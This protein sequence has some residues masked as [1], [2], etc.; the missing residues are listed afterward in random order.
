MK[1]FE[2]IT[3]Y[4]VTLYAYYYVLDMWLKE[5]DRLSH[6]PENKITKARFETID[7]V[8]NELHARLIEL[9]KAGHN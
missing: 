1:P 8:Y 6:N 3:E 7:K 2:T 9:E 5:S 4:Q